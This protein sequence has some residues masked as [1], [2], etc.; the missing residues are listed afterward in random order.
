[1][2]LKKQIREFKEI[3]FFVE[4]LDYQNNPREALEK[5]VSYAREK[6][7][8]DKLL[9]VTKTY[10]VILKAEERA[11]SVDWYFAC[12]EALK[13]FGANFEVIGTENIPN[14][15]PALYPSNHIYGFSDATALIGIL[16]S[17]LKDKNRILKIIAEYKV[18]MLNGI[19]KVAF[20]IDNENE[21]RITSKKS[22]MASSREILTYMKNGGDLT[23]FASG[24]ISGPGLREYEWKNGL[25][26]LAKHCEYVVPT[27]FSGPDHELIYNILASNKKTNSLR[28]VLSLRETWNKKGKTIFFKI[29]KPISKK[30]LNEVGFDNGK[31]TQYIREKC[32]ELKIKLK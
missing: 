4:N 30:E 9:Y 19:K 23:F 8:L 12:K 10:D 28:N 26:R 2:G 3:K 13:D 24:T 16:G 5:I 25:E 15:G 18:N 32:E 20:L 21:F 29:G 11:K 22:N 17:L 1:M 27:W 7:Y 6:P 31:V 14:N